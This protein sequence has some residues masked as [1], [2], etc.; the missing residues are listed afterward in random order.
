[1]KSKRALL[2]GV[3]AT[4]LVSGCTW[5]KLT[6]DGAKVRQASAAEVAA[7]TRV[8][9]ANAMTKDRVLVKR[10]AEKVQ[11]ELIVLAA[12]EAASMGGNAIVPE[13]VA[14]EGRQTFVVYKCE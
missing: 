2:I 3:G 12:N 13:G 11:E 6:A 5:V 9:V 4:V 7:C 1:M 8:G 14:V 10:S